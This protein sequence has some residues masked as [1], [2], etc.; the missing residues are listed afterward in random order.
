MS[1]FIRNIFRV[2]DNLPVLW[3]VPFVTQRSQRLGDLMAGTIVVVDKIEKMTTVREV[4]A[5]R[6]PLDSR[7]RFDASALKLARAEDIQAVEMIL[8]RWSSLSITERDLL[9]A[10]LVEP[11]A[12]RLKVESPAQVDRAQF[13]EDFLAAAYRRQHQ[14]LG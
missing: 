7:F 9:L 1:I 13:L 10:R 11:L 12:K 8:D 4:L 14:M 5:A 6:S 3:I 2:I